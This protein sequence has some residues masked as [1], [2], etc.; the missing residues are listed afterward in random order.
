MTDVTASADRD[1]VT[2][3][4]QGEDVASLLVSFNTEHWM[5]N[6]RYF[7]EEAGWDSTIGCLHERG[8][9]NDRAVEAHAQRGIEIDRTWFCFDC[10]TALLA[11]EAKPR[12]HPP[13]PEQNF[14]EMVTDTDVMIVG[15]GGRSFL[16]NLDPNRVDYITPD[17]VE[18]WMERKHQKV[19]FLDAFGNQVGPVHANVVP[20]VTWAAL[21]EWRDPSAPDWWNDETIAQT[22]ASAA[23]HLDSWSGGW[24]DRPEAWVK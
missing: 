2:E 9:F 11:E 12:V 7:A 10:G 1:Y 24:T 20:A 21:N 19:R 6:L 5:S 16:A 22:K 17:G 18:V 4:E 13:A 14:R 15:S 23:G 3:L 8:A